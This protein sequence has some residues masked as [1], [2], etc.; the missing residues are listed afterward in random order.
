MGRTFGKFTLSDKVWQMNRVIVTT[1]LDG[2]SLA[3][4]R[5]F[6]KTAEVSTHQTFSIWYTFTGDLTANV[7]PILWTMTTCSNSL[8]YIIIDMP[9]SGESLVGRMFGE[10][11]LFKRLVE[12]SLANE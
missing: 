6:A 3:N 5:R 4:H 10:F 1:T 9:Y 11:T 7:I 12:K 2:F 8:Q